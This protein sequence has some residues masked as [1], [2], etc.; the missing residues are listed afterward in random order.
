[1][2]ITLLARAN[3]VCL[4]NLHSMS[5]VL[6]A[7][8][9]SES[10]SYVLNEAVDLASHY[11]SGLIVLYAY[12]IIPENETIADYRN[13]TLKRAHEQFAM[14]EKMVGLNGSVPCEFRAEVG[15]ISDRIDACIRAN[16]AAFLVIGWNLIKEIREQK[17]VSFEEFV[18]QSDVPVLIVP[19]HQLI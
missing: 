2:Q 8:D 7:I 11:N 4:P 10:S 16:H 9:F 1:M 15:F 5:P 6:C 17:G 12:R 18:N 19:E 14:L 3:L 13:T